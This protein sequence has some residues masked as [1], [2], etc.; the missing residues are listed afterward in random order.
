MK[1]AEN[2]PQ[3]VVHVIHRLHYGGLEN[4]LVN[5]I[6]RIP[7]SRLRQAVICLAGY[8]EFRQRIQ[9]SDVGVYTLGKRPGKDVAVYLR[10]WR[11][12]RRLRPD[13]VHT[14]NLGTIDLQWVAMAA[15]SSRRIH[16]EHGWE[17]S[18]LHGINRK[19]V[20][21]RRACRP[22]IH[23]YVA[24]SRDIAHWLTTAI[25]I[26]AEKITQIYNGVDTVRFCPDG[27]TPADLPWRHGSD[28]RGIVFGTVG[29]LNSVKNQGALLDAFSRVLKLTHGDQ[30][31]LMVVGDGPLANELHQR[32][33]DLGIV[34][35]VWFTG[36][37]DD[38]PELLRAMDV[39][40]LPSLNEGVSNTLL[41]AM[42]TG[43]PVVAGQV[44]GNPELIE[45]GRCGI[46][47]D[48]ADQ[49]G[50]LQAMDTYCKS[51]E[52]RAA[53]GAAARQTVR[54]RFAL[55][56]MAEHYADLYRALPAT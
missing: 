14:R 17:A 51:P 2:R 35:N 45:S 41:E 11:L 6:N 29:R 21:I 4:G 19:S 49:I 55:E 44:G 53:H 54:E 5:I 34:D 20:M 52:T 31:R 16:G 42:A 46:L 1:P 39:F 7:A 30:S 32:A 37:R 25:G 28:R 8:S 12:L 13:I 15:G 50:L 47:Y 9:R 18:D 43:R 38:I 22:A 40:V 24:V 33:T 27:P 56:A 10:F 48:P 23:R 36:A 26:S 3:F